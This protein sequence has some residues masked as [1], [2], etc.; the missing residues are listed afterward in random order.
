MTPF[1]TIAVF[2]ET[3]RVKQLPEGFVDAET[4]TAKKATSPFG[5]VV[6]DDDDDD[7]GTPS[8]SGTG[9]NVED[10]FAD[11][12]S[13]SAGTPSVDDPFADD[14]SDGS[15]D[16]SDDSGDDFSD[17]PGDDSSGGAHPENSVILD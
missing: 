4:S 8:D 6:T 5:S 14:D 13:S 3:Y 2:N 12:A 9:A 1:P 10:P 7:A 15:D 16:S 17:V 11:D